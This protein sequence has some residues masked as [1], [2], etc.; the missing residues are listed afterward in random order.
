MTD[1]PREQTLS[2]SQVTRPQYVD[3]NTLWVDP[4]VQ[5][6]VQKMHYGDATLGWQGDPRLSLYRTP[7]HRWVIYREEADSVPRPVCMSRPG[8]P[9]GNA[10]FLHLA[11]HDH[12]NGFDPGKLLMDHK[13]NPL[14]LASGAEDKIREAH[15]KLAVAAAKDLGV[16]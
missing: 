16:V 8:L 9:L 1:A 5:E 13:G 7:D 15:E 12:R 10:V 2:V 3:G 11:A 6:F 4:E 14:S